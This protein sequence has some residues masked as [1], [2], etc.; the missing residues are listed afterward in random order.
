LQLQEAPILRLGKLF[1]DVNY[2]VYK[3]T[4]ALESM[5]AMSKKKGKRVAQMSV[6]TI[7]EVF[8]NNLLPDRKLK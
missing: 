1:Q 8:L 2:V 4:E 7:R 5:I 6:D 3:R